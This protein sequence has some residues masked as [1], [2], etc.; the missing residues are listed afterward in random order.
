MLTDSRRCF[1]VFLACH[2]VF[3]VMLFLLCCAA[4]A[5]GTLPMENVFAEI[6]RTQHI[7]VAVS[8][9]LRLLPGYLLLTPAF[10]FLTWPLLSRR[11]AVQERRL[12]G[13]LFWIL[14]ANIAVHL[15]SLGPIA[16]AQ[17]GSADALKRVVARVAP[18]QLAASI[19]G[20]TLFWSMTS[21]FVALV[22]WAFWRMLRSPGLR[23]FCVVPSAMILVAASFS[24]QSE[25]PLR[26]ARTQPDLLI[27]AAD[28]LRADHLGCYGY[29]RDTSPNID[30]L[31]RES[32][33]FDGMTVATA[34]TLESW[35]TMLTGRWPQTHGLRYMFIPAQASQ[36][37]S[38]DQDTLPRLL[39]AHGWHSAVSSNWAGNCFKATDHGFSANHASDIQN[40]DVFVAEAALAAHW[41]VPLHFANALGEFLF[42]EMDRVTSWLSAERLQE[43]LWA[44]MASANAV[45]KPFFGLLFTSHTHL[46]YMPGA[47]NLARFADPD[48]VGPNTRELTFD[49]DDFIMHGFP[50]SVE[51]AE[52][53]QVHNLYD[54][55]VRDFDDLVGRIVSALR[56]TDRL[57]HTVLI[58]TSDHG[59]DLYDPGTSLGHGTNFFGGDQ[60]TRIPFLVRLPQAVHAGRVVNAVTR[61]VDVMPT[62][63]GFAGLP[64]PASC[65]GVDLAPLL[66]GTSTDLS[67]P[68]F[69]ETCYLFHPKPLHPQG[70]LAV[71]PMSETLMVDPA[72]RNSF[73]LRPEHHEQ[74][75]EAKDNM[76]RTR[77]WKLLRLPAK[78]GPLWQLFDMQADPQQQHDLAATGLPVFVRLQAA[79]VAWRAG[80][81]RLRWTLA[82]DDPQR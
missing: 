14:P 59:D 56:A 11:K 53:L 73:V 51:R 30:A 44:E 50:D 61:G 47:E 24:I 77:R 34:S 39:N 6:V 63:L 46:P 35:T 67:L 68:A 8:A 22:L 21:V 28:S 45:D 25:V 40:L 54:A 23:G 10:A 65:E 9:N 37:I 82:D 3:A 66:D 72:F 57:E 15:L 29:S 55:C 60:T 26:T 49:I 2:T 32:V 20:P 36:R 79:L 18:A 58:I 41:A 69:A 38:D 7:G 13:S 42:P 19:V 33:R 31:A 52:R 43:R 74:V 16:L 70:A 48:Y 75:L 80:D 5:L 27:V 81:T 4:F 76:L 1:L 62:M 71:R 78:D 12:W 17:P 64:A